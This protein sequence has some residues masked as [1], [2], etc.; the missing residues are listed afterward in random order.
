MGNHCV[1]RDVG[2]DWVTW[3][4]GIIANIEDMEQVLTDPSQLSAEIIIQTQNKSTLLGHKR[5]TKLKEPPIENG[6]GTTQAPTVKQLAT[7]KST[8][9]S[10]RRR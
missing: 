1:K 10:C 4:S 2:V 8:L 5:R 9:R 6:S 7:N 3:Y